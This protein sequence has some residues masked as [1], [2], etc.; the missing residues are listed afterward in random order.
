MKNDTIIINDRAKLVTYV[1]DDDLELSVS[2]R[3]GILIFPG[4]GYTM[5]SR[6][7]AECIAIAF[8][9]EGFNAFICN[10]TVKEGHSEAYKDATKAL[11]YIL[12]HKKDFKLNSIALCGFSAGAHLSLSLA[13]LYDK[14]VD[15]LILGYPPVCELEWDD[16]VKNPTDLLPKITDRMPK[17][18]IFHSYNDPVVPVHNAYNIMKKLDEAGV[19]F[20]AHVFRS[21]GHGYSLGREIVSCGDK[22][23]TN[24]RNASWFPLCIS[25]FKGA[26]GDIKFKEFNPLTEETAP[27]A[28]RITMGELCT[29]KAKVEFIE[30][31]MPGFRCNDFL[32]KFS[33]IK[34]Y[35]ILNY[36]HLDNEEMLKIAEQLEKIGG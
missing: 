18:F 5:V 34:L 2:T 3:P 7:E 36:A 32:A 19:E 27:D 30:N 16:S 21:G 17:T 20:E 9:N 14:K 11:D 22:E 25:W 13:C 26:V 4:G 28:L 15:G 29:N 8:N 6:R 33:D 24:N 31:L 10:Y 12:E 1:L 23:Y 35:M